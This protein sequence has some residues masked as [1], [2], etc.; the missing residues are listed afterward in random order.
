MAS[1][2][3]LLRLCDFDDAGGGNTV[4]S[5]SVNS[6]IFTLLSFHLCNIVCINSSIGTRMISGPV[7][8]RSDI[9]SKSRFF[10]S[11]VNAREPKKFLHTS[12]P[13]SLGVYASHKGCTDLNDKRNPTSTAMLLSFIML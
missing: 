6:I 3:L 5:L 10:T 11:L 1:A 13:A 7:G 12:T 2:F 4:S 9:T 8:P